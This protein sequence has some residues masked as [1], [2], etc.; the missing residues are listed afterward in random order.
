[1]NSFIKSLMEERSLK[2][3][4]L[5]AILGITPSAISSWNE[6]GTNVSTDNLFSLSKLF[7]ITIDELLEGKR[8]GESLE[9]KWKREYD[10]NEEIARRAQIDVDKATFL[11]CLETVAKAND[12]FFIL[13]EKKIK[14][15]IEEN[16]SKELDYLK[17][18]Y[19]INRERHYAYNTIQINGP[20]S[21]LSSILDMIKAEVGEGNHA[22]TLWALKNRCKIINFDTDES[23]LEDF[24][25]DDIFCAWYNILTPIEKDEI[26][27][28]EF[29]DNQ[30]KCQ[31]TDYL[32]ELI[33]RGGNIL[34]SHSDLNRINYDYKDLDDFEGEVKPVPELDQAQAVIYSTYANSSPLK[35]EQY[36]ALINFPRMRQIEM[37]AKYKE[38]DP[39]KYWEYIKNNVV[40]I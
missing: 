27:S 22:A 9:D 31:R 18:F 39:V 34:Y 40:M 32:Y 29:H 38:K 8:S 33:K 23:I 12:R 19:G 13:F 26:I 6:E 14:G 15:E 17:R 24:D 3:K 4:D 11:Q 1:M 20:D 7:H 30:G 28:A 21:S 5:A 16:E 25:D 36:Q 37:E 2:Q 10:I 35:Y